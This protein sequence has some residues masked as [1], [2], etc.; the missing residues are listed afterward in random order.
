MGLFWL[1][2]LEWPLE[3]SQHRYF[4]MTGSSSYDIFMEVP[5]FACCLCSPVSAALTKKKARVSLASAVGAGGKRR[6]R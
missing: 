2:Y 1:R 6:R 3:K 4:G 5:W